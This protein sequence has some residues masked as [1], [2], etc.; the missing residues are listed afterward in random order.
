MVSTWT[1]HHFH[2]DT[3]WF[4][5][6]VRNLVLTLER[7]HCKQE[8]QTT[9]TNNIVLNKNTLNFLIAFSH[10]TFSNLGIRT[11]RT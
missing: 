7:G 9:K 5:H 1:S 2:I 10:F 6:T 4:P 8:T 11:W 3:T